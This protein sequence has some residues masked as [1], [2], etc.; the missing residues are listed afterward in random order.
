MVH[1]E[2][3]RTEDKLK[4]QRIQKLNTTQKKSKQCIT[5]QNKTTRVQLPFM[6]LGQEMRFSRVHKEQNILKNSYDFDD[7]ESE[8][9]IGSMDEVL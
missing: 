4:I 1:A 6:T 9:A 5:Q 8:S 2:K 7:D 3:Y